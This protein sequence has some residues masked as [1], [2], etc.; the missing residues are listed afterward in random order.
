MSSSDP[1]VKAIGQACRDGIAASVP[2]RLLAG[3]ISDVLNKILN[4]HVKD[5]NELSILMV[6]KILSTMISRMDSTEVATY[7]GSVF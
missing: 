4:D 5:E 2:A 1:K 6:F 7:N 3:P